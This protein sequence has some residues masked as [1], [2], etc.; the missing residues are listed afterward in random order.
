MG[1]KFQDFIDMA[2]EMVAE[3]GDNTVSWVVTGSKPAVEAPATINDAKPWLRK[4][5]TG[6]ESATDKV[7]TYEDIDIVFLPLDG[8]GSVF[9]SLRYDLKTDLPSGSIMAI[10]ASQ[11][12][13]P[14]LKD[15][16]LR[17]GK[18]LDLFMLDPINPDSEQDI[19]YIMGF[20]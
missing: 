14:T 7:K 9:K 12:F 2:K 4:K 15:Y 18:R 11:E 10:M 1:S 5:V 20:K 19:V 6:D 3:E 8:S 17:K 16:V 13:V